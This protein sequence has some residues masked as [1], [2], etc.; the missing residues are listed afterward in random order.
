MRPAA[1]FGGAGGSALV[2]AKSNEIVQ[3]VSVYVPVPA[4]FRSTVMF[5]PPPSVVAVLGVTCPDIRR[6]PP[7]PTWV[8]LSMASILMS[9]PPLADFT[10]QVMFVS[11][12]LPARTTVSIGDAGIVPIVSDGVLADT[13]H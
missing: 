5:V 12:P 2:V 11:P 13:V 3:S 1:T 9:N 7:W 6:L 8:E 4:A 10:E